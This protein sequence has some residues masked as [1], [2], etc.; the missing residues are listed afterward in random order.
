M[1]K[2]IAL[3]IYCM[4]INELNTD[5]ARETSVHWTDLEI[6]SCFA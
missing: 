6:G 2:R 3:Q 5:Q 4:D 1:E